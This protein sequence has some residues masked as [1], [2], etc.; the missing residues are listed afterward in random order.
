MPGS[1]NPFPINA[2]PP[3][4]AHLISKYDG[5]A[6]RYTSYPTALQFQ[7]MAADQWLSGWSDSE[8]DLSLYLHI[9][10]CQHLCYYCGCFKEHAKPGA[11]GQGI[12]D[13]LL[14]EARVYAAQM[15]NRRITQLHL[16]GGTPS[17]LTLEQ[18]R[19][20][21]DGLA[22][23]WQLAADQGDFS[24]ELDPRVVNADY[25]Q[26]LRELGFNRLSLGVQDFNLATQKAIHREQSLIEVAEISLAAKSLG[27]HGLSFDLIYGL[28]KQS[29]ESFAQTIA[30]VKLLNPDR[31][32]MYSYAHLPARFSAQQRISEQ[33]LPSA[34]EKLQM[35]VMASASLQQ[36]GYQQIGMDHFAKGK[37]PLLLAQQQG[38]LQRN[39][40]GYSTQAG[41]DILALGPSAISRRA[42]QFAQNV[43]DT[44]VYQESL[45]NDQLPIVAGYLSTAEDL[46]RSWVIQ[47]LSCAQPV[48]F[49]HYWQRFARH[50]EQ[51]FAELWPR[52][53]TLQQ[54][55]LIVMQPERISVTPVGRYLLRAICVLFDAYFE[56]Q[57]S[58]AHSR[59]L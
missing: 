44:K 15:P 29:V 23:L 17:F 41:L 58:H 30:Q 35:L 53:E 47:Q 43:K 39:F 46:R 14:Q 56:P 2:L 1:Y 57:T 36:A 4:L 45:A 59:I 21:I 19:T 5:R 12:V 34:S 3:D 6:P 24:I 50:F 49:D 32:A 16:G 22:A 25:L 26:G 51:D 7:P 37:D 13:S 33:D 55:G 20:L 42:G 28:P 18:M 40:Q 27:F 8:T 52:L 48:L 38:R 31:V 54:D 11:L 10:Y 9:P